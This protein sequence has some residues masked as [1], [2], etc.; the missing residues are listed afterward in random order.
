MI[1]GLYTA[2]AGMLPRIVEQ[3]NIATNLANSS[4]TGYKKGEIFLRKLIDASYALDRA[5][6]RERTRQPEELRTDY[7]QGT[8]DH[9]DTPFDLGLNGPGFFRVRD[10]NR[11]VMYTRNGRF[12]LNADRFLVNG[13][14]MF[15][16]DNRNNAIRIEGNMVA[17]MGN[18]EILVDNEQ[19]ATIG[20]ADF[21]ANGYLAIQNVGNS[22]FRKPAAVN[23]IIPGADTTVL[24]GYLEDSNVE[25][26]RA[27]VDMIESFRWFEA[28][29]KSIQIQDQTLQRVV[30]DLGAVR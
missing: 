29:Q 7:L 3:E 8:L 5:L 25:P 14:G 23:E 30:I 22:L 26:I 16:L 19:V 10:N 21:D 1:N 2:A 27:M 13:S 17:V 24:Q 28:G 4:T 15:L 9:T 12:Y 6:G 11:E 20:I 18:G